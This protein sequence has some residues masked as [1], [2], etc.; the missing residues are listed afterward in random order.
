MRRMRRMFYFIKVLND[1]NSKEGSIKRQS[2]SIYFELLNTAVSF[3]QVHFCM[4]NKPRTELFFLL[5]PSTL[6]YHLLAALIP[7]ILQKYNLS[8]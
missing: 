3:Q 7:H 5:V 4:N 6:F 1:L 2:E 8:V